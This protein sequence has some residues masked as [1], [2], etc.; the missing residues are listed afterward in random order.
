MSED[1]TGLIAIL[2]SLFVGLVLVVAC[3]WIDDWRGPR[4]T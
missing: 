2:L 3:N 4:P 1:E